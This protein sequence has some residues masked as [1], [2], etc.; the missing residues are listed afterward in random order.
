MGEGTAASRQHAITPTGL[1]VVV[2]PNEPSLDI[3][4]IHGFK[5]HPERTWTYKNSK[6]VEQTEAIE[7]KN[8]SRHVLSRVYRGR[9][10]TENAGTFWP[11][12]LLPE[13]IP[14]ARVL[15]YGYDSKIQHWTGPPVSTH[16]VYDIAWDFL[17]A[18]E[19]ERREEP[20]RSVLFIAHSLGGIVVKEL[21]RRSH[22]CCAA[23]SHLRSVFH[24]TIGIMFFG[25]PHGGADPRGFL[26]SIAEKAFRASGY[27]VN[28][29][30]VNSLLP[31]SER[32][33]ELRDV[34]GPIA[35]ERNWVIHSFQ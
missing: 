12:Y 35:Q 9:T 23:Q 30:V 33:R 15:T 8:R 20:L 29:Q 22:G 13:I 3:V 5:G 1:T 7:P 31:S 14:G 26:L 11:Q 16:T 25:T 21:L 6:Q 10:S 17:V 28:E 4:F 32:L 27:R 19:A 2:D 34:F 24:A 18:L